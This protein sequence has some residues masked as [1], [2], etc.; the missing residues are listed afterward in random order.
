MGELEADA[1]VAH[2]AHGT[3]DGPV[4]AKVQRD[5]VPDE[6]LERPGDHR[7]AAREVDQLDLE[8]GALESYPRAFA[9]E[10]VPVA[11]AAVAQAPGLA[12]A[13]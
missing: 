13:P 10:P 5:P 8:V 3:F 12:R 9:R 6:R 1:A 4:I 7:S 11:G 2:P